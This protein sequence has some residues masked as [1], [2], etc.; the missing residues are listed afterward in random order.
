M[1]QV[2]E[3]GEHLREA[4]EEVLSVNI[5]YERKLL[6]IEQTLSTQHTEQTKIHALLVEQQKQQ[7]E[8][9]TK[10]NNLLTK[11]AANSGKEQK[12]Q[13]AKNTSPNATAAKIHKDD[14]Q[15]ESVPRSNANGDPK[16]ADVIFLHDSLG[17]KINDTI[18][19]KENLSTAKILTYHIGE[20][21]K[22]LPK[23]STPPRACI[24]HTLTND[25]TKG[26]DSHA[27]TKELDSLVAHIKTVYPKTKIII[28]NIAPR[29]THMDRVKYV[30]S[31]MNLYHNT[32]NVSTRS[33]STI[34][35]KDRWEDGIH[36]ED[37]GTSILASNLKKA[38]LKAL[39]LQV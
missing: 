2:E 4:E 30:N 26:T 27:L 7:S 34:R 20:V 11:F 37:S 16:T 29:D 10:Q 14:D 33:N 24:I 9:H 19:K 12:Q 39:G 5:Q 36:L 1:G 21:R 3:M 17:K 38:T 28:S 23:R 6:E 8:M 35:Y 25:I 31:Y 18:F 15:T 32:G 13:A 22:N